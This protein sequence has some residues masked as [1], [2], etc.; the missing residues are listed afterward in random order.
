MNLAVL[1][2]TGF[3]QIF[4]VTIQM[5]SIANRKY[6]SAVSVAFIISFL[7]T[8]NVKKIAF[9]NMRKRLVYSLGAMVGAAV[10]LVFSRWVYF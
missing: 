7:W 6:I 2:L 9:G 4:L 8:F 5:W 3:F 10:G 1:F